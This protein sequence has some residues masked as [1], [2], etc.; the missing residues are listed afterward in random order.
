M[1]EGGELLKQIANEKDEA[2]VLD[3]F[4]NAFSQFVSI[5]DHTA[6]IEAEKRLLKNKSQH[7]S[8]LKYLRKIVDCHVAIKAG[9]WIK[10]ADTLI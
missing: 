6:F 2:Q 7:K 1:N 8:L 5:D 4:L 10:S 3:K 9:N